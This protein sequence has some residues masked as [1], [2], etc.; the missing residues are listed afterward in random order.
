[1]TETPGHCGSTVA[2]RA[3]AVLEGRAEAVLEEREDPGQCSVSW[4]LAS[5]RTVY[6]TGTPE[7]CLEAL[8]RLLGAEPAIEPLCF[9]GDPVT[10]K[11]PGKFFFVRETPP[12]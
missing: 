2:E 8:G 11:P 5:G 1:M 12:D 9:P 4:P 7:F 6:V 10:G 3:E